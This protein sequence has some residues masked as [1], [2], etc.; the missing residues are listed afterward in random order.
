MA[1]RR[2][3][4]E[5]PQLPEGYCGKNTRGVT[6]DRSGLIDITHEGDANAPLDTVLVFDPDEQLVRS[7][8]QEYA[9]GGQGIGEIL[10]DLPESGQTPLSI[11]R[12][13]LARFAP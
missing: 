12:F 9:G 1:R 11:D 8:G 3:R 4:R 13:R 6:V 5:S 10:A 2:T 7:F